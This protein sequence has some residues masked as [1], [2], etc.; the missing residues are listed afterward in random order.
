MGIFFRVFGR[1]LLFYAPHPA[2]DILLAVEVLL[3]GG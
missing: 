1:W 3:L 2:T